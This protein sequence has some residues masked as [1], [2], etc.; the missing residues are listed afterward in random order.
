MEEAARQKRLQEENVQEWREEIDRQKQEENKLQ[1][2]VIPSKSN[3][4][5]LLAKVV[6]KLIITAQ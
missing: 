2:G 4:N 1:E 5:H 3:P 6:V